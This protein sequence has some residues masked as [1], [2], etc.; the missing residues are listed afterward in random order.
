MK[1]QRKGML[2]ELLVPSPSSV[3]PNAW[4][5]IKDPEQIHNIIIRVNTNKLCKSDISPFACGS[6]HD[7]LGRFGDM[8]KSLVRRKTLFAL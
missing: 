3:N 2:S 8:S 1:G 6:L 7:D 5:R 4:I